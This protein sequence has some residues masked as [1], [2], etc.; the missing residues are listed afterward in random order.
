MDFSILFEL[1]YFKLRNKIC[2]IADKMDD[3]YVGLAKMKDKLNTIY[4]NPIHRR[5]EFI[6]FN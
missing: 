2:E 5:R 4:D 3:S 6:P 1:Y